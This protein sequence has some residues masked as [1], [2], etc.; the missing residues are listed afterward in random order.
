MHL[1]R[2]LET[3]A[4]ARHQQRGLARFFFVASC[5]PQLLSEIQHVE[6]EAEQDHPTDIGQIHP[7]AQRGGG[8]NAAELPL[9]Y[10]GVHQGLLGL[11]QARMEEASLHPQLLENLVKVSCQ[12]GPALNKHEGEAWLLLNLLQDSRVKVNEPS[13]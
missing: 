6:G 2:L 8:E 3:N 5:S 4:A 10:S 1:F 9:H 13:H 7:H 11:A 12:V